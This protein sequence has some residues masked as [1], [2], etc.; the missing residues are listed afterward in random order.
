M[1]EKL[2]SFP[3]SSRN[4]LAIG[5]ILRIIPI[6]NIVGSAL[7]PIGW[8]KIYKWGKSKGYILALIGSA[9][10]FIMLVYSSFASFTTTQSITPPT[11]GPGTGD[12]EATKKVMISAIDVT[13]KSFSNQLIHLSYVLEGIG[14]ILESMGILYLSK[15]TNGY[16]P[17]YLVVLFIILGI[18]LIVNVP[19]MVLSIKGLEELKTA[20]QNANSTD[21]VFKLM[22]TRYMSAMAPVMAI[23]FSSFIVGLITYIIVGYK[24]WKIRDEIYKL[25]IAETTQQEYSA[26][27]LI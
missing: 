16:F 7:I 24:F 26:E 2:S 18:L 19:A 1:A 27:T 20:I 22:T 12:L 4:F 23:G 9:L 6:L 5:Y 21:E 11:I 25:K 13:I 10:F 14:L 8:F 3:L 17:K 15:D